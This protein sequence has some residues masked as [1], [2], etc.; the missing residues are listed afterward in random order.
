MATSNSS[1]GKTMKAV[2][3]KKPYEITT[4]QRP[5]PTMK[6]ETDVVVKVS[7]SALCGSGELLY[8]VTS[9]LCARG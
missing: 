1:E 5:V 3:I 8:T 7:M 4:E 6:E 2:I 9:Q